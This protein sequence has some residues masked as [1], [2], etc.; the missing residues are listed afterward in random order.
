MIRPSRNCWVP[1]KGTMGV[2]IGGYLKGIMEVYI[3][4]VSSLT[5]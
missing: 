4:G 1:L 3:G 5:I 2:Y